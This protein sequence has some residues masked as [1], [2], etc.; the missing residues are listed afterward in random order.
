MKTIQEQLYALT[1]T[2]NDTDNHHRWKSHVILFRK[3][4]ESGYALCHENKLDGAYEFL[5]EQKANYIH[6][7]ELGR[8]AFTYTDDSY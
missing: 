5:K 6:A 3:G 4:L 1:S 7:Y 8:T 2:K